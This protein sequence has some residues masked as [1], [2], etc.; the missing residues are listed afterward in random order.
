M[1]SRQRESM[2]PTDSTL[3]DYQTEA[4]FEVGL[5]LGS[6]PVPS[7]AHR[8]RTGSENHGDPGPNLVRQRRPP[9]AVARPPTSGATGGRETGFPLPSGLRRSGGLERRRSRQAR[10]RH[11]PHRWRRSQ[12]RA[13]VRL[14]LCEARCG[15]RSTSPGGAPALLPSCEPRAPRA[16]TVSRPVYPCSAVGPLRGWALVVSQSR[17]GPAALPS[18]F[19]TFCAVG[20]ETRRASRRVQGETRW[21]I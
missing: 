19:C 11:R 17:G 20:A 3:A 16:A 15:G 8:P 1:L 18:T 14:L 6:Y 4:R 13:G 21:P 7:S 9:P 12:R 10:A 2:A 5:G